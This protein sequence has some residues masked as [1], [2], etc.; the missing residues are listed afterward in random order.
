M[1]NAIPLIVAALIAVGIIVI[2]CFYLLSPDRIVSTFYLLI[3][4]QE[5]LVLSRLHPM[6][7]LAPGYALKEFGTS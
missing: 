7:T 4:S 6:L 2:G 3:E 1:H 5:H